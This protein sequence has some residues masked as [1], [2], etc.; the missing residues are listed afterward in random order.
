MYS[1]NLANSD[2]MANL[3]RDGFAVVKGAIPR[4]RALELQQR[5]R[6]WLKSFDND[7][8]DFNNPETWKKENLP[9]HTP[10]NT[11]CSYR[12][13][14]EKFVWDA[15][16]E[17]GVLDAF[18][19]I[20]G[21]NELLVSFD[22]LNITFPNRKDVPR[23][24]SWEHVDQSPLRRGLHCIQGIINLSMA[25]PDDGGLVVY[26]TSHLYHDDWIDAQAEKSRF[27]SKDLYI[28][29]EYELDWYKAKGL[30]P[31]KVCADLGD[32]IVWD[33]RTIHY[34]AE[35]TEASNTIR[36][37][38]YAS[39]SPVK[40]ASPEALVLK[41]QVFNN[42]GGTTHWAHDNIRLR[43]EKTLLP[44]GTRDPRDRDEPLE[45]PIMTDKLLQLAGVK[46]Y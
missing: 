43:E 26:P 39:Y 5:A 24:K 19:K 23:L 35:P 22:S 34:G 3:R 6:A 20:W 7:A 28:F 44:D 46:P 8:L 2:W 42:F 11:F 12:V 25:G 13:A 14:H 38:I 17:P 40:A 36:T 1:L 27:S 33:S 30:R 29:K 15:R 31:I 16:M 18:T 45:R 9:I 10:I 41:A 21:T 32:L 4:P 37:V